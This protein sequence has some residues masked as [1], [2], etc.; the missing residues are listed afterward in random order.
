MKEYNAAF[1]TLYENWYKLLKKELGESS[2][3]DLFRKTMAAGLTK[4][5]GNNFK[6]GLPTEFVRLVEERDNN[7]G[8]QVKFPE[9]SDKKLVYQFYT[10]PFPNLKNEVSPELLDDTYIDFKIK[11]ILGE[12]WQYKNTSHLWNGDSCTEFVIF[13]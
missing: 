9:V 2:A 1:F 12:E 8:L 4:A 6:K 3:L 11:Y 5:Y 10:D 7:V 13:K